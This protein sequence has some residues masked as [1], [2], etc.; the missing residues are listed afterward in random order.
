MPERVPHL[1]QVNVARML[2]PL[3][4][5]RL[6]DF[7]A[8]LDPINALADGAP[9]FVWRLQTEDGDATSIRAFDDDLL[10]VNMSVWE[11]FE[12]LG[13]F[14][15][16]SEHAGVMRRRREW[17][18]QM[19][20]VYVALWWIEA[21]DIPTVEDAKVRLEHLEA[22]GPTPFAFTFKTPFPPPGSDLRVEA[23]EDDLCGV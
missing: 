13:D 7:V 5:P 14:V 23:R 11:S 12:A 18:E 3:D 17:F 22:N 6:A 1:A 8:A 4:A 20:T 19:R 2:E 10:L 15:Y 21:G 9:G 16:R